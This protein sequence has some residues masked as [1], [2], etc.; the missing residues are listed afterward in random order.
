[1]FFAGYGIEEKT[2]RSVY[3]SF[4]VD[5]K[6]RAA[7]SLARKYVLRSV[8]TFTIAGKYMTSPSMVGINRLFAVIEYLAGLESKSKSRSA[9]D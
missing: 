1:M 3:G 2:F 4:A 6:V 5:T 7:Q 8:P 9:G